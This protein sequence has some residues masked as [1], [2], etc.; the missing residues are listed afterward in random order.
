MKLKSTIECAGDIA[1]TVK[2]LANALRG[3]MG[4][5]NSRVDSFLAEA[6]TA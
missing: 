4:E 5:L 1:T 3:E 6:R 2:T